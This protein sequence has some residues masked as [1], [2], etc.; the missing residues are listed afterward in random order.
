M[1]IYLLKYTLAI[2]V[3]FF[4][5]KNEKQKMSEHAELIKEEDYEVQKRIQLFFKSISKDSVEVRVEYT[6]ALDTVDLSNKN[7]RFCFLFWT[8]ENISNDEMEDIIEND[9]KVGMKKYKIIGYNFGGKKSVVF[10]YRFFHEEKNYITVT[11]DD[12]VFIRDL[13]VDSTRIIQKMSTLK[14]MIIVP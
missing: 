6:S 14:E 3:L 12:V 9:D 1:K 10:K 4:S 13:D 2:L 7:E 8:R 5:C 11:V